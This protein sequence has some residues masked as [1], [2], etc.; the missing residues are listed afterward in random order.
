MPIIS[1][2]GN[3]GAGKSTLLERIQRRAIQENNKRIHIIPESLD[4]WDKV[5]EGNKSILQLF[6]EN[7]KKYAMSFQ[8]LCFLTLTYNMMGEIQKLGKNDIVLI[9]PPCSSPRFPE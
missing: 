9:E 5:K 8:I 2:E 3:I 7:K 4:V 1:I 6:Y